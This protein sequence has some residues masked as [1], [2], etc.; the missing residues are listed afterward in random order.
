MR[1]YSVEEAA[2]LLLISPA[3]L[4]RLAHAGTIRAAKP[5]RRW[6]FLEQDLVAYLESSYCG[7]GQASV[8]GCREEFLWHSIDEA[9][10]GGSTSERPRGSEYAALLGLRTKR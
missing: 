8:G 5:G 2:S 10:S 3:T 4:R 7:L 6:V 9:R 1:T